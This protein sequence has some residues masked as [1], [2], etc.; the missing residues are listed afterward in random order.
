M[1]PGIHTVIAHHNVQVP[2]IAGSYGRMTMNH[3]RKAQACE[4]L[5][6]KNIVP[7]GYTHLLT[8][9]WFA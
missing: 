8:V 3:F 7:V 6:A 4:I 9:G 5:R 2:K 1:T